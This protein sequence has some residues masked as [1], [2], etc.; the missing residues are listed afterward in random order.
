MTKYTVLLPSAGR[1]SRFPGMRPKWMLVSPEGDLMAARA[2][3]SVGGDRIARVVIGILREHEEQYRASDGIRRALGENVDIVVLD[4]VTRGPA[5]TAYEMIRRA[6]VEGPIF[7]KDSD[8]WFSLPETAE[9]NFVCIADLR[10]NL[11]TRRVAAKSFVTINQENIVTMIHE[12]DVISNYINA[13]GYCWDDAGDFVRYFEKAAAIAGGSEIFVSH[14][15]AHAIAEGEVFMAVET[16]GM[17]DNG[18]SE[19]WRLYQFN[20]RSFFIDID[21]VVL[22]N[23]GEYFPPY[24]T[25]PDEP[26]Q[27]NVD[28]LLELQKR[29]GQ[30]IFVTA[31][32]ARLRAKLEETLAGLGLRWSALVT[33]CHHS[34]RVIVNDYAAS[35]PYP[36]CVAV[37]LPRNSDKLA[38]MLPVNPY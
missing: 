25:D 1:S 13:G 5:D 2:L 31:R 14:V 3:A 19:E 26:I 38:D 10:K 22:K 4:E 11:E 21:G 24:W 35:N 33:D 29:G 28:H 9:G 32:P 16:E 12:K 8:S 7:I 37:N 34:Q 6:G 27:A 30:F 18:T 36:S 20:H 23:H 17:I 15:I